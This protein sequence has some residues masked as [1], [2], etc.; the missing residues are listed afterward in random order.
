MS[1]PT[2]ILVERRK[3]QYEKYV[4]R[5]LFVSPWTSLIPP[6]VIR[7]LPPRIKGQRSVNSRPISFHNSLQV[8][9]I[10][11]AATVVSFGSIDSEAE[12][13]LQVMDISGLETPTTV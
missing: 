3:F 11:F 12:H 7:V 9:C 4:F 10:I 5:V 1:N 13:I 6:F 8:Y 2:A